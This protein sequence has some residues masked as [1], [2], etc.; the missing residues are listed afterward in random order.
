[1]SLYSLSQRFSKL[2][3]PG[4]L[5]LVIFF[6]L[7]LTI[8]FLISFVHRTPNGLI[9]WQF[10]LENYLRLLDPIYWLGPFW[11]SFWLAALTTLCCF[12]LGY[13]L[14]Y[15]IARRPPTL[16]N[17][18]LFLVILPFLTNFLVRIYAWFILLR[19]EGWITWLLKFVGFELAL[20]GSP[21]GVL[22]GLVYGYLPFM[23]LPLYATLERLDFSLVEAASDL[24]A[25]RWQSFW[26][27]VFPLSRPGMIAGAILV[28]IPALGEFI[29]PKLL[30]GGKV[31]MIGLLIEEKFL[32]RVQDWPLGAALAIALMVIVSIVLIRYFQ[33]LKESRWV[34]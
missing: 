31:P 23:I 12:V 22:V 33:Q 2:L 3:W 17:L 16:R 27:V 32:G 13:P 10:S 20:L 8:I 9:L 18:L 24:G 7:P 29:T 5:W 19:P 11:N 30:G 6:V 28:F 26:R 4:L 25:T 15:Y 21:I 1:M 14:A 34:G